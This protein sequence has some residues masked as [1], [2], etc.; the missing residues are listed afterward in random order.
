MHARPFAKRGRA[1]RIEPDRFAVQAQFLLDGRGGDTLLEALLRGEFFYRDSPRRA[2]G[3][4]FVQRGVV[5]KVDS[6]RWQ[7]RAPR[8]ARL[9][10]L[11][12]AMYLPDA[13]VEPM[14]VDRQRVVLCE[15]RQL[16]FELAADRRRLEPAALYD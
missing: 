9:V 4:A 15:L 14:R 6:I 16:A 10:V 5:R 8:I 13:F 12:P 2:R 3:G 7:R 11:A 1:K